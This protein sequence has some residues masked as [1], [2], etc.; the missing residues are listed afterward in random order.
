[1]SGIGEDE[2]I[3]MHVHSSMGLHENTLLPTGSNHL[4]TQSQ[5]WGIMGILSNGWSMGGG[6]DMSMLRKPESNEYAS[7]F[8]EY[9]EQVPE[10]SL[11]ELLV[12]QLEQTKSTLANVTE[13]Q[14]SYRYAPGKWSLKEVLGHM[15]D[16]ERVMSY[17]L[18]RIAR[19][20]KTMLPGFIEEAFVAGASFDQIPVKQLIDEL[21]F[22]RQATLSLLKGITDEA[23]L[24][25]GNA[26]GVETSARAIAYIIAG[27]EI[28]HRQVI[29]E[30]Y[31][32][33]VH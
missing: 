33:D 32:S 13:E 12:E 8:G 14:G 22:V 7:Y 15:A 2:L 27:H 28:H 18:L 16:T 3:M 23:W 26:N 1:M 4:L 24:R 19:G 31:L 10:G 21:A 29:K 30:R 9:V 5:T 25:K 17:R 11:A 6:A 20:D